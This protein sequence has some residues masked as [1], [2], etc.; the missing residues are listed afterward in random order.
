M[1]KSP[2][3]LI[4]EDEIIVARDLEQ[5]LSGLGYVVVGLAAEGEE[6]IRLAGELL[7]DLI[8]MD[9]RLRGAIDGVTA[10]D[11]IRK[12]FLL[13]CVYLTAHA[14]ESTVRRARVTEPFGYILKPFDDR[15]LRT[16]IEMALYKHAAERRLRE[17]EEQLRQAQ[18]MEAIGQLAGGIAHQL[19]NILTAI[20]LS[21]NLLLQSVPH[22]HA[23]HGLIEEVAKAGD[24]AAELTRQLL[25]FSRKQML[26]PKLVDVNQL[27]ARVQELL[28]HLLPDTVEVTTALQ[29][30]LPQV[31]VDPGQIEQALL[32]LA[33]NSNESM[34]GKGAITLSTTWTEVPAPPTSEELPPPKAGLANVAATDD[35]MS[36]IKPGAYVCIS[37]QDTG[38]GMD[39]TT[40]RRIFE[41]FFTNKEFGQGGL[42][43]ASVHGIIEQSG[44]AVRVVSEIGRGTIFH[45]YL[46]ALA[47][48]K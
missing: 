3:V 47:K 5:H 45:I 27:A 34:A 18:K 23:W 46:P 40:R 24:R 19:N 16:V 36:P 22:D 32:S 31:K 13:P 8:L 12:Q 14:D 9:I 20:Q 29:P 42:G 38:P 48:D 43:L 41:P 15:E 4:V 39:E 25:A 6:G 10:A 11:E 26:R 21:A 17:T 44:G 7:P 28:Q 35:L 1:T 33:M 2:R 37:L 30:G